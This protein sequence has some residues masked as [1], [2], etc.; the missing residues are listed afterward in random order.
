MKKLT[1]KLFLSVAALAV[2]AATLVSTTFAWY[3]NNPTAYVN[4]IEGSTAAAST[5]GS[6]SVS[7][8]G[9]NGW[10][11]TIDFAGNGTDAL[12]ALT[13]VHYESGV[14]YSDTKEVTNTNYATLNFYMRADQAGK[15][16]FLLGVE[17]TTPTLPSQ[18]ANTTTGV[19]SVAQGATFS[20]D[21]VSALKMKIDIINK[22]YV[23]DEDDETNPTTSLIDVIS[24]AKAI[25]D[26]EI[27]G[28]TAYVN[29]GTLTNGD[30]NAYYAALKEETAPYTT[31]NVTSGTLPTE[32]A[33]AQNVEYLVTITVWLEGADTDCFNAV[34]GQDF[35]LFFQLN[36]SDN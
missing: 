21:A 34:A 17:N 23:N 8:N 4:N 7:K 32:F 25:A 3:V 26:D 16:S 5:D 28:N 13:P 10:G 31:D 1:R 11:K 22:E 29:K 19:G 36:Y 9:T 24:V 2:C 6:I 14:F 33:M 27:D 20:V 35:N 18:I 12:S 30:A 15:V